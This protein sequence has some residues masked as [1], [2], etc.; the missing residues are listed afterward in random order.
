[1]YLRKEQHVPELTSGIDKR[2]RSLAGRVC[3]P[4]QVHA[5]YGQHASGN[6]IFQGKGYHH[7]ALEQSH[8]R[9]GVKQQLATSELID[10]PHGW[11]REDKVDDAKAHGKKESILI[12]PSCVLFHDL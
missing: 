10:S 12:A 7:Q 1:M 3:D 11:E 6:A 2:D 8:K 9:K 5:S 4:K